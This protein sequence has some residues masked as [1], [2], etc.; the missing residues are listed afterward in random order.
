MTPASGASWTPP[1]P[2]EAVGWHCE[3][4]SLSRGC[5]SAFWGQS[6]G[7]RL[8]KL[9]WA[10]TRSDCWGIQLRPRLGWAY[11]RLGVLG[12]AS[13]GPVPHSGTGPN[14]AGANFPRGAGKIW[15]WRELNPRA[16]ILRAPRLPA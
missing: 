7:V 3:V 4:P 5:G 1:N 16:P 6:E 13:F 12:P 9:M 11:P 14:Y 15:R 2:Y 8:E 10:G